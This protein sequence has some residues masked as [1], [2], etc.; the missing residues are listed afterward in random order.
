[1]KKRLL[2]M[3]MVLSMALS[4]LPMSAVAVGNGEAREYQDQI[5]KQGEEI[6]TSEGKV[7]HSKIIQQTGENTFGITLQVKT[8]EEIK[9]QVVSEDAAVVLVLDQSSSMTYNNIKDLKEAVYG[10]VDTLTE[11]VSATARRE[12]AIV[13]FGSNADTELFWTNAVTDRWKVNQAVTGIEKTSNEGTNIEGGLRLAN[14]LLNYDK[15]KDI[16]NKYVI[17]M[18]DG[19]PTF[20][21]TDRNE[22]SSMTKM[23]GSR[24]GG[25]S[26]EHPDWHDIYCTKG[27][28]DLGESDDIPGQIREKG[29][30]LY[31]VSYKSSSIKNKKVNG[32]TIDNWL[33]SFADQHFQSNDDISLGLENIAQIIVNQAKAWILTDPMGEY[34]QFGLNE[35]ITRVTNETQNIVRNPRKYNTDTNTLIWDLKNDS[36]YEKETIGNVTWYTYTLTYSVTLNNLKEGF[37]QNQ[38]Y[39]TNG[40]TKLTYMVRDEKGDLEPE[41]YETELAVPQVKGFVGSLEFTKVNAEKQP[42]KGAEFTLKVDDGN[43]QKKVASDNDGK[44]SFT[45]IPSGHVYTLTETEAPEGYVAVEPIDVTVSYGEVTAKEITDGTLIDPVATGSLAISKKVTVG[46]GLTPSPD[47]NFTFSVQFG[48]EL[49]GTYETKTTS[50]KGAQEEK[51]GE[52]TVTNGQATVTLQAD[53]TIT[54]QGLPAGTTYTVTETE[55]GDG[56]T[57]TTPDGAATGTIS[58]DGTKTAAFTNTYEVESASLTGSTALQVKKEIQGKAPETSY[59]W[60]ENDSFTFTIT[61]V[62]QD[63]PM[64]ET[65][66]IVISKDTTNHT[67]SFGDIT[68]T[69]PGTYKYEIREKNSEIPGM[70]SDSRAYQ[71]QVVVKDTGTGSLNVEKIMYSLLAGGSTTKYEYNENNPMTFVNTYD[72]ATQRV[73]IRGTKTL[74]GDTLAKDQFSF[75]L[76]KAEKVGSEGATVPLPVIDENSLEVGNTVKNT[77][78]TANNIFFGTITYDVQ[79]AGTYKYYFQEVVPEDEEPG[80]VYDDE[81]KVVTVTVTYDEGQGLNAIVSVDAGDGTVTE[82]NA[83]LTFRN[84]KKEATLGGDGSTALTVNKTLT[85]RGWLPTDQFAFQLAAGDDDTSKA[86]EDGIVKLENALGDAMVTTIPESKT[87]Q[88]GNSVIS[89]TKTGSFGDITFYETGKYTF[90]VTEMKPG[91]GAI[92]GVTYS[93][94]KY[95]VTVQVDENE[96]GTLAKPEVT[97]TQTTNDKGDAVSEVGATTLQFTNTV[98]EKGNTKSVTTGTTEDPDGIDPDGKVAGVGDILTYTIQWVNDA[99]DKNGNATAATVIVTDTIPEGTECVADGGANYDD[100]AKTLTWTIDNA[101]ANATGEV[102]FRV[103]VTEAAVKDDENNTIV[104]QADVKVGNNDPKQTTTTETYVPEKSITKY[105]PKDGDATEVPQTGLKVGDQLTY[106]ISYKNTEDTEATVTITDK[107]PTGTEFVSADNDGALNKESGIV[108]WTLNKVQPGDTG[109]VTMTVKVVSGAEATVENTASVQI[110]QDGPTVS[111]NTESTKIDESE[112]TVT[113]TPA[114]I[115]VYTGGDGYES[116]VGN[117]SGAARAGDDEETGDQSNGLPEPGYYITLPDWLNDQ[118]NIQDDPTEEG[119]TDLSKILTFTYADEEQTREWSLAL[120]YDDEDGT[121]YEETTVGDVTRNR[122]VYRMNPAVVGGE[123]I[124]V[125]VQFTPKGEEGGIPT[126]SDDFTLDLGT[127]YQQ[128]DMTIYPGLLEQDLVEA[129]VKLN[130]GDNT[131]TLPVKVGNGTLT[132]R[133]TT[134]GEVTTKV[135]T[136]TDDV[137]KNTKTIDE[138]TGCTITAV[139]DA[140]TQYVVN[141]SHVTVEAESV[142]LLADELSQGDTAEGDAANESQQILKDYLVKND[143][144]ETDDHYIYQYLDLVDETNG[145]AWVTADRPVDVYWKLPKGSD[146]NDDFKLVHFTGLDRQYDGDTADLIGQEGYEVEAYTTSNGGL[147]IVTLDGE[148]YLKF[149]TKEFSPFVLVWDEVSNSSGGGG[150]GGN[151]PSLNTED[152]YGYIVGYPVDYETG[153]PTDDQARKP[154]KPQG[155]I[156]RAEVATIFFRMLTDE[157]RN[158]Y[159]SQSNSFTD[160]AEDAWYN[161]AISTMANAGILDGYEDGSFHPNGYITRAEFA[162]IAVRFFDLS[163][164]GEDLFPDI[165]GHWAQDYINQ[166]ADAGIIEGYPDGTFG[167]QKQITRAEAVTMVNRTLDRHP[168]QD[169]FLEDMLVW[170]DNLDTEAWYYADIQEATN[171]HEY[172]VKKDAQ[173]NEYEV[174]TKILPIRDWEALEKEWSDA[175]SSENPGDVAG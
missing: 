172:Q 166:A 63:A 173:G 164:Q 2:A 87:I 117:Q 132:V 65:E 134:N 74:T 62:T 48:S 126:L 61:A 121:S 169:H 57:Q 21:V 115:I 14:N 54:I 10:F 98:A 38:N 8:S 17:L 167:P 29:A 85:G 33:G 145:R 148:Q 144:A 91:E 71:V 68:Y 163:Y 24:G 89:N 141:E 101:A 27:W 174:W 58:A 40:T 59:E 25:S 88:A 3:L 99:V 94:A 90:T 139:A 81:E 106:T 103:K 69:K 138:T 73:I 9:E 156:T 72:T 128:Y 31:T 75:A 92:E 175:N 34:I 118:L 102:S 171:S 30:K 149:A 67:A 107:V 37:S 42:L 119:A 114:D 108:T 131:E 5:V 129:Q 32:Q 153:E 11:N 104:N 78:A 86:L 82:K 158:A 50:E 140:D 162:T 170:P 1:M 28:D 46:D 45:D 36:L 152:H 150:G 143:Q 76:T 124:P 120:Y 70:S 16:Q 13:M 4:I 79:D 165:D 93:Q 6:V 122:Y 154:V 12:I 23:T 39:D 20:Y 52:L 116:V 60:H 159:W 110:G 22:T 168:D 160:V 130:G 64:P 7:K 125:R 133:G 43:W 109:E 26:A 161:N 84:V 137:T 53:Q 35:G 49:S 47:T 151:K 41:L 111:T 77:E 105:Q 100:T 66:E 113:I 55:P 15:I 146:S 51:T 96:D 95:T 123:K 135:A 155:K 127:L 80:M 83:S 18:T 112:R 44:I 19:V 56:F 97:V 136:T 142:H 157:S 147:E